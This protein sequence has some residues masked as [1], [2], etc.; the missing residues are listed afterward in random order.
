MLQLITMH[1]VFASRD[2]KICTR[3]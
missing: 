3:H 1:D 2:K